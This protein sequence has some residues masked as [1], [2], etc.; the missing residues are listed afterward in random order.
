VGW[1]QTLEVV[2]D[3]PFKF[4]CQLLYNQRMTTPKHEMMPGVE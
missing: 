1:L 3:V 2:I 4:A